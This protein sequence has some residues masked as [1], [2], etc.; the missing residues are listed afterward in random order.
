MT[1]S[2]GARAGA[3]I[4]HQVVDVDQQPPRPDQNA[5]T[6]RSRCDFAA[7]SP[8]QTHAKGTFERRDT[9]G[10]RRLGNIQFCCCASKSAVVYDSDQA[11]EIPQLDIHTLSVSMDQRMHFENGCDVLILVAWTSIEAGRPGW[12]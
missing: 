1:E 9:T 8:Q 11:A 5:F 3:G 7:G 4:A 12:R 2:E 10:H 6:G